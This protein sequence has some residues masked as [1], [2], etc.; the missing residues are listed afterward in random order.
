M[1]ALD[2][3]TLTAVTVPQLLREKTQQTVMHLRRTKDREE[4]VRMMK[5]SRET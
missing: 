3:M 1:M 5:M 2:Q 4:W